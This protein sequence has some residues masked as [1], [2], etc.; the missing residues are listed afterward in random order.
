MEREG[1]QGVGVSH[2]KNLQ[3]AHRMI[4][5]IPGAPEKLLRVIPTHR[6][7]FMAT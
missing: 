2:L 3:E 4:L 5:S 6:K 7:L 1:M